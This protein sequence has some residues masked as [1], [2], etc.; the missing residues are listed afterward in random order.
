RARLETGEPT[1]VL[2][3]RG[4]TA[5]EGSPVKIPG[6]QRADSENV[7]IDPGW[8]R[9][10]FTVVYSADLHDATSAMVAQHLAEQG[11]TD[12]HVLRGG[13]EAWEAAQGPVEPK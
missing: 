6:A 3:V 4:Q 13:F 8:P 12:V 1:T 5:W 10:R 2:D 7:Q 9:D 11:F